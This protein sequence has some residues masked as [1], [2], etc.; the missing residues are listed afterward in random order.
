[1]EKEKKK[2][3]GGRGE[4]NAGKEAALGAGQ[5]DDA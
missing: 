1:M 4:L 5:K 3:K 2:P